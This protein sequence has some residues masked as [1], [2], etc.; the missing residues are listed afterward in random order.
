MQD[1][2]QK[3]I[4]SAYDLLKASDAGSFSLSKVAKKVG[5]TKPAIFRHFANKEAFIKAVEDDFFCNLATVIKN[6]AKQKDTS[7]WLYDIFEFFLEPPCYYFHYVIKSIAIKKDAQMFFKE[8][9]LRCSVD[10]GEFF[11]IQ[12]DSTGKIKITNKL[13]FCKYTYTSVSILS[14][15]LFYAQKRDI[16]QKDVCSIEEYAKKIKEML[17]K[18]F[19]FLPEISDKRI[20]EIKDIYVAPTKDDIMQRMF[21]SLAIV[22]EKRGLEG[23]TIEAV[24]D[25]LGMSKSSLYNYFETKTDMICTLMLKE[26]QSLT[27][28]MQAALSFA[29]TKTEMLTINMYAIL[30]YLTKK[31]Y[32]ITAFKWLRFN[33]IRTR[34][35]GN[36]WVHYVTELFKKEPLPDF[37]VELTSENLEGWVAALVVTLVVNAKEYNFS[38]EDT[39]YCIKQMI[40]FIRCGVD[41]FDIKKWDIEV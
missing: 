41:A 16:E 40:D 9:L 38:K 19:Y 8:G 7:K 18:G 34:L 15:M 35:Q 20:Q 17:E 1:T 31:P 24:A 5:L 11:A 2:R 26:M 32:S 6:I 10:L 13:D 4:L 36:K 12:K 29:K 30:S 25:E 14:F 27:Q 21:K 37:G 23:V 22:M 33:D 39:D 28:T 3:L